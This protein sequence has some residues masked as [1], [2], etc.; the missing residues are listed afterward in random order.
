MSIRAL[1][2]RLGVIVEEHGNLI[3]VFA[4]IALVV[5]LVGAQ[6]IYFASGTDTFVDKNSRIYQDYDHLFLK[7]FHT[8]RIVLLV[9]SDD[10]LHPE[11]LRSLDR[12]E[13]SIR[14]I[15]NVRSVGG[16]ADYIK[17]ANEL[18]TGRYAIPDRGV[19]QMLS[20][21]PEKELKSVLP[22]H[23]NTL[24]IVEITPNLSTEQQ[25]QLITRI[26]RTIKF[27]DLPP[28]TTITLTGD[29]SF[30]LDLSTQ[31]GRSTGQ[32]LILAAILMVV[33]LSL[34]FRYV[35]WYLLP[36]LMVF[37]GVIY[38]FGAMGITGVPMTMASMAVFPILI[39]LGIDYAIQFHNRIEEELARREDHKEAIYQT[40]G[41][42]GPAVLIALTITILG[43]AALLSSE[44]PMIRD[45]G[46][47]G[48]MG[49][50]L[51][52]L[53]SLFVGVQ[54]ICQLDARWVKRH[55]RNMGTIP[56]NE[57]RRLIREE[58]RKKS[59]KHK[60]SAKLENV[61]TRLTME[62]ASRPL[63]VLSIALLLGGMGMYYDEHVEIQTN[64]QEYVPQD[65]KSL[66]DLKKMESLMG[67]RQDNLNLIVKGDVLDPATLKWMYEFGEHEV[68]SHPNV[69]STES[70]ATLLASQNG[71]V[72]PKTKSEAEALAN[73]LPKTIR[74]R[75]LSGNLY[76]VLN[77]NIGNAYAELGIPKLKTLSAQIKSDVE[78]IPPPPGVEVSLTGDM[79][80]FT[81]VFDALTSGRVRMTMLGLVLIFVA[82]L[83][84]YRDWLRAVVP[85][86][87]MIVV[88]GWSGGLMY[89]AHIPYT[90][91]TGTMGAL[92]LGIGGEYT[93]LMMERYFEER[94][95]GLLP[96]EALA[97]TSVK[98][99]RAILASG[100]TVLCGFSALIA[101]AFPMQS[102]F[103]IVTVIDMLFVILATFIVF[104]PLV[105]M[106]DRMRMGEGSTLKRM[107][108]AMHV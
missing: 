58:L 64:V 68:Q 21:L 73:A 78:W 20:L 61:L 33:V 108:E 45:F 104:P 83:L 44:V 98:I 4:A 7:N 23:Q 18:M 77:L 15:E 37:F 17:N 101:S 92:I 26:E 10:V 79:Y 46:V 66:L 35:R 82:L 2:E 71:G 106:L 47:L 59:R 34:V 36:L 89:I 55:M 5:A 90:P 41:K 107:K 12:L 91:L 29:A 93:V 8:E 99:G 51:C 96:F 76:A 85:V 75:Y 6:S 69:H 14:E 100:L 43:F 86:V 95:N 103:G 32:L 56:P 16:V 74:D 31:M 27:A 50:V 28:S 72:L 48:I 3:L 67:G 9:S 19:E 102:N 40:V 11:V 62:T 38:T 13:G 39:G 80:V 49:V 105:V 57:A 1:Y 54:V 25:R 87:P 63:A 97:E 84:I 42:V 60:W 22:D 30:H 53:T 81:R 24:I 88:T 94:E 65:M 70:I 52:Y